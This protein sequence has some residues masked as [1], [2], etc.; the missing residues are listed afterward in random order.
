MRKY[1]IFFFSNV[2]RLLLLVLLLHGNVIID[3][4][5]LNFI[6][7]CR[8]G[9]TSLMNQYPFVIFNKNKKQKKE[10]KTCYF[11]DTIVD[12]L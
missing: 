5:E 8:V 11:S 9:K 12:S 4:Y 10:V 1:F 6:F 3:K 7:L 2:L